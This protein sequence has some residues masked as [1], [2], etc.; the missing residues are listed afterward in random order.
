MK[1]VSD[2]IPTI[3]VIIV[4]TLLASLIVYNSNRNQREVIETV[5]QAIKER[6]EAASRIESLIKSQMQD[7]EN[8]NKASNLLNP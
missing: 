5:R 6:N 2:L 3:I 7:P 4:A 8:W 1:L